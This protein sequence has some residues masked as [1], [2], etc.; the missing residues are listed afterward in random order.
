MTVL[1]EYVEK[2]QHDDE[3]VEKYGEHKSIDGKCE[4]IEKL[5][6]QF[7]VADFSA[8]ERLRVIRDF[9]ACMTDKFALNHLRKLN[10]QKI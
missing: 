1:H 6:N 3:F 9:I 7:D 4:T 5:Y 10:G 2:H 8:E